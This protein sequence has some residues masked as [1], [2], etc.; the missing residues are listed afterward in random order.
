[1]QLATPF[2]VE[3][4][5]LWTNPN[6]NRPRTDYIV[7]HHAAYFYAPGDAVRSIY[8]YHSQKWP[9]YH[10]AAYAEIIQLEI[11]RI[12]LGC[13]IMYHPEQIGAGVMGRN[14][15]TF[16]ICAATNF[17]TIPE[18]MWI[19]ALAQRVAVAQQRYPKAQIVGHKEITLPGY[20]TTCPGPMW[21]AWKPRLTKRVAELLAPTAR[22][23]RFRGWPIYQAQSLTGT[24]AGHVQSGEI[25][26]IDKTYS[27]GAGHVSGPNGGPGFI[28][29]NHDALDEL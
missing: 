20:G 11:D 3:E 29:L 4:R 25:V 8:A 22:R 14:D 5:K 1:M 21:Q 16:H 19:E 24:L 18:D 27:N 6:G 7:V 2:I 23:L 17:T 26:E 12:S 28:D 9:D 15:N 10:A 13:H